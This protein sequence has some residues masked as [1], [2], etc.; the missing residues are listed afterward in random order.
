[1]DIPQK[2]SSEHLPMLWS[3]AREQRAIVNRSKRRNRVCARMGH[4]AFHIGLACLSVLFSYALA[5]GAEPASLRPWYHKLAETVKQF[6]SSI[7]GDNEVITLLLF[8]GF[9]AVALL[10]FPFIVTLIT[11][12]CSA[13]IR[14][15]SYVSRPNG[16]KSVKQEAATLLEK[17]EEIDKYDSYDSWDD[18][19]PM[20]EVGD[21]IEVNSYNVIPWLTFALPGYFTFLAGVETT[22]VQYVGGLLLSLL[23]SFI[24]LLVI[25]PL[26]KLSSIISANLY[27]GC[28]GARHYE[29]KTRLKEFIK[30][31]EKEEEKKRQ[32]KLARDREEA[33]KKQAEKMEKAAQL[34]E[35]AIQGDETN[36]ELL[37]QA[38]DMGNPSA[39]KEYGKI[40]FLETTSDL[41]TKIEKENKCELAAIYL[42][43]VK[44]QDVE[45]ELLWLA[46][47]IRYESNDVDEWEEILD[48][49]RAI[50]ASGEISEVFTDSINLMIQLLV[51][52]IDGMEAKQ[53]TSQPRRGRF[54]CRFYNA[55][56][57]NHQS[58]EYFIYK[59]T[60]PVNQSCSYA[61]LNN[62][63]AYEEL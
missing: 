40:L 23:C 36:M 61:M 44:N 22:T 31:C 26:W 52:T 62:G 55:G 63:I 34:Y 10:L 43:Q 49:I 15:I 57:C 48:R 39:C 12:I 37:I 45:A 27:K 42:E 54:Y 58:N 7:A 4:I 20:N 13:G 35:Q 41:Y 46:C 18:Y 50:K 6:L 9:A 59:C 33:A 24:L 8:A 14:G 60:D 32:A 21:L 28:S 11:K 47:R 17:I 25:V 30:E 2:I 19:Y 51:Q 3:Y 5:N 1:M 56:I 53:Q 16:V 38:A 29:V